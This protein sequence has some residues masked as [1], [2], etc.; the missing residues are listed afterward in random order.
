MAYYK[1]YVIKYLQC[2]MPNL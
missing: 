1:A 2:F